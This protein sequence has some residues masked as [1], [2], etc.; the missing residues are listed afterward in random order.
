MANIRKRKT[1]KGLIVYYVSIRL[2]GYKPIYFSCYRLEE[3][4]ETIKL[5]EERYRLEKHEKRLKEL[6]LERV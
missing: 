4:K 3:A 5:V 2:K 6:A 1:K